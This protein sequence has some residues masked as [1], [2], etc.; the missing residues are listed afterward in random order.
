MMKKNQALLNIY[1]AYI[2]LDSVFFHDLTRDKYNS[3]HQQPLI[4]CVSCAKYQ[5]GLDIWWINATL[6]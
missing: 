1:H 4:A 5:T 3:R 6:V 2:R